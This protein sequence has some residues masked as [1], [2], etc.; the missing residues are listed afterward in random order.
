M[1]INEVRCN[2][3]GRKYNGVHGDSNI[4]RIVIFF[5]VRALIGLVLI[6]CVV[7]AAVA[8]NS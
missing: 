5:V 1:I 2:D 3:C 8:F 7:A 4:T 6:G